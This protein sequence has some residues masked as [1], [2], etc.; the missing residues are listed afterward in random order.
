MSSSNKGQR[1]G[2]DSEQ[3]RLQVGSVEPDGVGTAI[4]RRVA[5]RAGGAVWPSPDR[6]T[7]VR[8]GHLQPA[9]RHTGSVTPATEDEV[10][11]AEAQSI[12]DRAPTESAEQRLRRS[13]YL[14]VLSVAAAFLLLAIVATVLGVLLHGTFESRLPEVPTWQAV[15]GYTIAVA[16][17]LL[18]AFGLVAMSRNNRTRW[19]SPL[20]ALTRRQR[21]ELLAQARGLQPIEPARLPLA[22]DMAQQLINQRALMV[23]NSGLGIA[24]TGQ[25]IA[26]PAVWRGVL[27]IGYG[28]VLAVAWLFIQRDARRARRFLED[29]PSSTDPATEA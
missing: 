20:A 11:W 29:H 1:C 19:R 23:A 21:K 9:V 6:G 27:A 4:G 10:R 25:W 13:R 3:C 26:S 22:R 5:G 16:G 8:S 7:C 14:T 24:F 15:I 17:L 2:S 28:V 18:Q 12:L